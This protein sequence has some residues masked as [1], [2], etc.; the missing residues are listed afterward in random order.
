MNIS[1][2]ITDK[3]IKQ[4]P[5]HS[6]NHWEIMYYISG[7]GYLKTNEEN[8]DFSAG[9][10]IAVPPNTPHGSVSTNGFC[11]ISIGADFS[12][13]LHFEK[14]VFINDNAY[15]E[16]KTLATLIY[17]NRF[18][19]KNLLS[20][21]SEAFALYFLENIKLENP[22]KISV[23][24][25]AEEIQQNYYNPN[26]NVG[27]ILDKS[28]YSRDYIRDCFT[29]VM[30]CSPVTFLAKVRIE[31]A[32][33]LLEIYGN[34]TPISRI[35]EMCGYIDYIYFSKT[36]SKIMGISPKIYL[37]QIGTDKN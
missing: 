16:G 30:G 36:F 31:K 10:I 4:Y 22:A 2:S 20:A 17:K 19:S 9:K 34:N 28:G 7:N 14:P 29:K 27:D 15:F 13:L 1:V 3:G 37:K 24:R 35:C 23:Y 5:I 11:N 32:C 18:A 33:K 25:I 26:I 6:H 12:H 21:L 8:I